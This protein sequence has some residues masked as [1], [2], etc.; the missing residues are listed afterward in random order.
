MRQTTVVKT[1]ITKS[2]RGFLQSAPGNITKCSR[3]LLQ[4]AT[5]R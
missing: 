2:E 3:T 1:F 5:E 4:S